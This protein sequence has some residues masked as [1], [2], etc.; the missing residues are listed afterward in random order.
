MI[1]DSAKDDVQPPPP[2]PRRRTVI[3]S[4]RIGLAIVQGLTERFAP[5][6]HCPTAVQVVVGNRAG[7]FTILLDT[8]QRY[9]DASLV[10]EALPHFVVSQLNDVL[11]IITTHF[12]VTAGAEAGR[13]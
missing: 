7:S 10:D 8:D 1:G 2:P 12:D 11:D 9:T 3:R 4:L 5:M 13:E 6:H